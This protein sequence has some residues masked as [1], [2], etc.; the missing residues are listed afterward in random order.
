MLA[1]AGGLEGSFYL[2]SGVKLS[3]GDDGKPVREYLRDA[4]RFTPGEGWKRLADL[5]RAV[6]AAPTPAPTVVSRLVILTG[7]DGLNV[8]FQPVEK[9]PGFPRKN[10]LAYDSDHR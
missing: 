6:A 10:A 8:D 5:P 1:V 7:D 9:H 3:A 4:Y 2:F